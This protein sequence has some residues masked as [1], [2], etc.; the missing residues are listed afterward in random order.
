[1]IKL[2]MKIKNEE[3]LKNMMIKKKENKKEEFVMN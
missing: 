1:M 2:K 3:A